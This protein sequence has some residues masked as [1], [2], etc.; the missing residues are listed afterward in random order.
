MSIK[1]SV[2]IPPEKVREIAVDVDTGMVVLLF[3]NGSSLVFND[4]QVILITKDMESHLFKSIQ[5]F[6]DF[7]KQNNNV[8]FIH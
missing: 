6:H 5:E 3:F 1:P 4:K 7:I 8:T 2:V